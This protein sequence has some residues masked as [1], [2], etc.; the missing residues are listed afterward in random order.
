M[1]KLPGNLKGKGIGIRPLCEKIE[2][3]IIS[4]V[5][6]CGESEKYGMSKKV[7]WKAW[8]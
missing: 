4:H 5:K 2:G 1:F 8:T 3:N 7:I 6:R